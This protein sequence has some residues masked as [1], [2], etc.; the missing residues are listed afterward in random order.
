[1][2]PTLAGRDPLNPEPSPRLTL[3]GGAVFAAVHGVL[4]LVYTV[5]VTGGAPLP[6]GG[7]LGRTLI[8]HGLKA[9]LTLPVWWL[10]I[11]VLDQRS[12]A[13]RLLAHATALP[14]YVWAWYRA[15]HWSVVALDATAIYR[16]A[17][18]WN[19]FLAV[20]IYTAQFSIM[21][22]A[23]EQALGRHR[24]QLAAQLRDLATQAELRALRSQVLPHFLFNT[25]HSLSSSVPRE[26]E[27][28]RS[29]I[30]RL[31]SML[32]YTLNASERALV[33]VGDELRLAEDY[34][35]L[36]EA[37]LGDRLQLAFDIDESTLGTAMP[38]VVL[39][40][41]VENALKHGIGTHRLGGRVDLTI[42]RR[43]G[44]TVIRVRDQNQGPR[45][46]RAQAEGMGVGLRNC[47]TRLRGVLGVDASLNT[48][49]L[50]TGFEAEVVLPPEP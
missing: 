18:K 23:R 42:I 8:D 4:A 9:L 33:T 27:S 35:R 12:W 40:P 14:V 41:L 13:L 20:V 45:E 15:Y 16:P 7:I 28:L 47:A 29:R 3:R 2:D 24:Q 10:V 21:H 50:P 1:M 25:L 46:R 17:D 39:Q 6:F 36:E 38:P 11:R 34:L 49:V 5:I 22:L 37:R 43:D 48:R 30:A 31:G 44:C 32:R 19:V 26:L